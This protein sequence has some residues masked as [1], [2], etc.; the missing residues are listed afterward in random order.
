[1]PRISAQNLFLLSAVLLLLLACFCN[2]V[3]VVDQALVTICHR[4]LGIRDLSHSQV[5][6]GASH[7]HR[8]PGQKEP[9]RHGD[10]NQSSV[11]SDQRADL[12]SLQTA[13][14]NE[15]DSSGI[16]T[17]L[18]GAVFFASLLLSRL[19]ATFGRIAADVPPDWT[20]FSSKPVPVRVLISSPNAPPFRR[21]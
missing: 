6:L 21:R 11:A 9:H 16:T 7:E 2:S 18:A 13:S 5:P 15:S 17:L 8:H 14:S 12:K 19:Y 10:Q 1:M 20:F 4:V 3:A